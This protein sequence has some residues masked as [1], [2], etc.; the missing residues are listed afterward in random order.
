MEKVWFKIYACDEILLNDYVKK[1]ITQMSQFVSWMLVLM[2]DACKWFVNNKQI[3]IYVY[4]DKWYVCIKPSS[5]ATA[6][7]PTPLP[8]QVELAWGGGEGAP[9][10]LYQSSL[11]SE[12][13]RWNSDKYFC[14]T[15]F[16]K[17]LKLSDYNQCMSLK[18]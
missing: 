13:L 4:I 9:K 5:L 7:W 17:Y 6:F 3:V 14:E 8:E 15:W 10:V 12:I 2:D 18:C 16:C 11:L 1:K